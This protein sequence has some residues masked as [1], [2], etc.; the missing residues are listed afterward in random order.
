MRI[1]SAG[2][3][4]EKSGNPM[5]LQQ[6]PP[7]VSYI[8]R[9]GWKTESIDQTTIFIRKIPFVGTL[10]KIQRFDTPPFIPKLIPFL[11]LHGAT[12]I[13][14]EPSLTVSQDTY[15]VWLTSVSKFFKLYREPFMATKTI[16]I[17][18][19]NNEQ[20]IFSRLTEAK[21]RAVRKAQKN[22]I[23][24]DATPNIAG[25]MSIK[26]KGAGLFGS[27]TTYGADIVWEEFVKEKKAFTLLAYEKGTKRPLA[28]ILLLLWDNV[29]YYWIAGAT[30]Q[31][32]HQFAPTLLVWEAL[33]LSKQHGA[34]WFDFLGVWDERTPNINTSWKGFTKFKEGFGGTAFYYPIR[35]SL[36]KPR[37]V[38]YFF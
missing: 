36:Q 35:T 22:N 13:A 17:P 7:Y 32:K 20:T 18:L 1:P 26:A 25:L 30:K 15:S 4:L 19:K 27:I 8:R 16:R 10:A 2:G 5:E 31:G 29:S 14:A 28:G 21:R 24:I 23:I 38:N 6:S 37:A 9:L 3:S 34:H 33:R 11:A 12:T